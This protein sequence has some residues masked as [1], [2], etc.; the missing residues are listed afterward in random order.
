MKGF[1]VAERSNG[2][3]TT[4]GTDGVTGAGY[5]PEPRMVLSRNLDYFRPR[6]CTH[7][8]SIR[9]MTSRAD[10]TDFMA[11]LRKIGRRRNQCTLHSHSAG[12]SSVSVKLGEEVAQ[13]Q[14]EAR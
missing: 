14:S 6:Y 3:N 4:D 11:R 2:T 1:G 5:N 10:N 8:K 7:K 12:G 13:P 9:P